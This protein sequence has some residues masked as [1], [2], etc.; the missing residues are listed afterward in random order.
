MVP[1]CETALFREN[2]TFQLLL[3]FP[4]ANNALAGNVG[5]RMTPFCNV[6]GLPP[7]VP[8][9]FVECSFYVKCVE[10]TENVVNYHS[11]EEPHDPC[12]NQ[13]LGGK[14]VQTAMNA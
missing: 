11:H 7:H 9:P 3:A 2:S 12:E 14:G 13:G 6:S 1:G 10:F 5:S 8:L 4:R